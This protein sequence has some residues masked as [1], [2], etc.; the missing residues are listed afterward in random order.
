MRKQLILAAVAALGALI[1]SCEREKDITIEEP[2]KSDEVS[3]VLGG[4]ATR[5]AEEAP[6]MRTNYDLGEVMDG[7]KF[8]LEEVVTEMGDLVDDTPETR[9]TPAYTQ[10]VTDVHGH[11]FNGEI[12]SASGRVAVDGPFDVIDLSGGRKAWRRALGFDAWKKANGPVSFYLHMP[13]SPEGLSNLVADYTANS[14]EFDYVTP[15]SAPKQQ[16]IL[17]G[18]RKDLSFEDYLNEYK[19]KG[20]ASV[21]FR[22]ALTGVK[23]AIGNNTTKSGNRTPDGEVQTFITKVEITGLKDKGHAKFIPV[24]TETVQDDKTEFSSAGSFTWT[25]GSMSPTRTTVY[26]QTFS[27]DDIQDFKAGDAVNAAESF[28][29]AGQNRNLNKADASLTFWFV[30]QEITSDLEITVTVKVWS[31]KEMGTTQEINL[32]MGELILAQQATTEV[33]KTWK[34][35]QIRTFTLKPNMVDV[36]ITDEVDGYKKTQVVITNTG[37]TQ[38]YIR[39]NIIAN[40]Y[41]KTIAGDDGIAMGY[42]ANEAGDAPATPLTFVEPWSMEWNATKSKYVDNYN[43]EFDGLP[44][45]G[46]QSAWVRCK[47]GYF[48]FTEKVDPGKATPTALFTKYELNTANGGIIPKVM[49]L[50][51]TGGYKLFTDFRLMMD[52]TVQAIEAKADVTDW[53]AAWGD[54][55]VLGTA[56]VPVSSTG[57]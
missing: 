56:P 42:L 7:F 18:S 45:P 44:V 21:L 55:K 4:I 5:S 53:K 1:C 36:D 11:K 54:Q 35:G 19:T 38:A 49:Y 40:W 50:S 16:D 32:K 51:T 52:L 46:T 12:W 31:G 41:G 27:N 15:E 48:Y 39:A 30:P 29:K 13:S 10:N 47:D 25:D 24:G 26:T 2:V 43:G 37:N 8:S 57:E 33:N 14:I 20:G 6:I 9:G 22:H 28:Y 17:F 34:A 23:F 3:L